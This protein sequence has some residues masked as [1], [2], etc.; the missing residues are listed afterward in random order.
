MKSLVLF[1]HGLGGTAKGT[2]GAFPELIRSD[3][4]LSARYDVE[5]FEYPTSLVG[6]TSSLQKV[7]D[8]LRTE[9]EHKYEEKYPSI[10][11]VAH[12][13]GGLIARWLIA[14][15]INSGRWEQSRI[16]R[17]LTFATP[18]HGAGGATAFSWLPFISRQTK[19]LDPNSGFMQALALA[20]AQSDAWQKL[21]IKYVQAADDWIVG[22]VS[23]IGDF[24]I[25]APVVAGV[26]HK[27]VVKPDSAKDLSFL[28]AKRFLL[29][30]SLRPSGVES[31]WRPPV[32][33]FKQ[34]P[35]TEVARFIFGARALPFVGRDD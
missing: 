10:A 28:V 27:L 18:H 3:P 34:L 21:A 29:D 13:Q 24:P 1:V 4:E 35:Q 2:W 12:S 23:A 6:K 31:D 5:T 16:D 11:I 7:A 26:G 17:L 20:W 14:E 15:R 30:D 32:L 8:T 9:I 25:D 33:R 22:P 19:A